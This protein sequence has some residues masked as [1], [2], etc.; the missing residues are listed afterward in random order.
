MFRFPI[1]PSE[2][3]GAAGTAGRSVFDILPSVRHFCLIQRFLSVDSLL[4]S[5]SAS[6]GF[7]VLKAGCRQN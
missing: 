6:A 1:G 5:S 4:L 2:V 3:G 7:S